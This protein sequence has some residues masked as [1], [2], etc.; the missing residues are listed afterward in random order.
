MVNVFKYIYM[1]QYSRLKI[2][3]D[4]L[5][6]HLNINSCVPLQIV[7]NISLF[8]HSHIHTDNIIPQI[9]YKLST[10]NFKI[11]YHKVRGK[12][13]LKSASRFFYSLRDVGLQLLCNVTTADWALVEWLWTL[14]ATDQVTAW[15]EDDRNVSVHTYFTL[16]L[17]LQLH[18]LLQWVFIWKKDRREI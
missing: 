2:N 10:F 9:Y 18:Q 15:D 16:F 11:Q 13:A 14:S 5:L 17:P 4:Y 1:C 7:Q 6:Y 3:N 12:A 8:F